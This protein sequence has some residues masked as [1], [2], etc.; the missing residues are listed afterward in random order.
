MNYFFV[1]NII[2]SRHFFGWAPFENILIFFS[3]FRIIAVNYEARARGVT[4]HMRGD[5]AKEHCPEIELVHVPS[6]REKA[7]LTKYRDAGKQ[8]AEVLQSFTQLLE[9]ASIDEAYLDITE[10]VDEVYKDLDKNRPN[11]DIE[12]LIG[13]FA[14]GFETIEDYV[15]QIHDTNEMTTSQDLEDESENPIVYKTSDLKLLIAA[16]IVNEIRFAVR[17]KTG[18]NCSAGIAHNKILA[19]L[20][21]GFHKP[22]KQTCLPIKEIPKLLRFVHPKS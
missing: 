4:R 11:F 3:N 16:K 21:C 9:R 19:K 5:E 13:T 20:T 1:P 22:N 7:D 10:K 12:K 8:V 2:I 6:V 14:V 18:Y 17:E 15:S